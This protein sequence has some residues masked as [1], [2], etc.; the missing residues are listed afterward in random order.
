MRTALDAIQV[1]GK[2]TKVTA[3][4]E[5]DPDIAGYAVMGWFFVARSPEDA[6]PP[7][8]EKK[9]TNPKQ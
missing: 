4:A 8:V 1:T 9:S 5:I 2:G 3:S 7:K 6:P